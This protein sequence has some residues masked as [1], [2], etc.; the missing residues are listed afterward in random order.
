[1]FTK[2]V[3]SNSSALKGNIKFYSAHYRV[4]LINSGRTLSHFLNLTVFRTSVLEMYVS[5]LKD[6]C[7]TRLYDHTLV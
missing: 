2:H 5:M 3:V 4:Y 7:C 1:M 6:W